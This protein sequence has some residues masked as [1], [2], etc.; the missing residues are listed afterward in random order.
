MI[1]T[2]SCSAVFERVYG[3]VVKKSFSGAQFMRVFDEFYYSF[4]PR[5]ADISD[6]APLIQKLLRTFVYPLVGS[7]TFVARIFMF[8]PEASELTVILMGCVSSTLVSVMY[9]LPPAI[10]AVGFLRTLSYATQAHK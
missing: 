5:V 8:L 9:A 7:L 1:T 3:R 6:N 4:N 2:R 10:L